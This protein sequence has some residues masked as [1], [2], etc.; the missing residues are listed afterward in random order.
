MSLFHCGL[1]IAGQADFL[2]RL[3]G[4]DRKL[5]L[6]DWKRSKEIRFDNAFEQMKDPVAHL[7]DCNFHRYALQLNMY[8]YILETEYDYN[9]VDMFLAV[10]HPEPVGRAAEPLTV[11]IPVLE[12]EIH[13][14][15]SALGGEAPRRGA[16]AVFH[17][18]ERICLKDIGNSMSAEQQGR[19]TMHEHNLP[20]YKLEA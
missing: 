19:G 20:W 16:D 1:N 18:M 8:R 7:S 15:V 4:S 11:R 13:A 3:R 2:A 14:I 12:T 10:F 17:G 5:V 6:F 9:V